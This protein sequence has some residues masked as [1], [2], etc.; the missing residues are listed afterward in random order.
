MFCPLSELTGIEE[1]GDEVNTDC[2]SELIEP[3]FADCPDIV[4]AIQS[5][6]V[7]LCSPFPLASTTA[8]N[9]CTGG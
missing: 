1:L 3:E 6:V 2:G 4:L 7:T 8:D 9:L 5:V